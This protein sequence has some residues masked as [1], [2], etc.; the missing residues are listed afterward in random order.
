MFIREAGAASSCHR[1]CQ[2]HTRCHS[3]AQRTTRTEIP[4][5]RAVRRRQPNATGPTTAPP[6]RH[7]AASA[8]ACFALGDELM[9]AAVRAVLA[10]TVLPDARCRRQ[11]CALQ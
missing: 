8:P 6:I 2:A 7:A 5:R 10:A 4:V 9:R 1:V 3:G 11:L